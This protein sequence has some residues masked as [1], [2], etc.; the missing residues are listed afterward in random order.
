M[1]EES[2]FVWQRELVICQKV[3]EILVINH[4]SEFSTDLFSMLVGIKNFTYPWGGCGFNKA[5]C[6]E[7]G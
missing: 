7:G 6:K 5:F 3:V 2:T 4:Q 1:Q